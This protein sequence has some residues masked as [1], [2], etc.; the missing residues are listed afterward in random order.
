MEFISDIPD[1]NFPISFLEAGGIRKHEP[2]GNM[3][4]PATTKGIDSKLN[5]VNYIFHNLINQISNKEFIFLKTS[6]LEMS[7]RVHHL[8]K[9]MEKIRHMVE[10]KVKELKKRLKSHQEF[11]SKIAMINDTHISTAAVKTADEISAIQYEI[12]NLQHHRRYNVLSDRLHKARIIPVSTLE[13]HEIVN[14]IGLGLLEEIRFPF[15]LKKEDKIFIQTNSS[16]ADV[17]LKECRYCYTTFGQAFM[18]VCEAE[19]HVF[20]SII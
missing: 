5:N 8:N 13:R 1:L 3:W 9:E 4:S 16:G 17:E 12:N 18:E 14:L 2:S 19:K 15:S 10:Q 6:F 20:R 11:F 7:T